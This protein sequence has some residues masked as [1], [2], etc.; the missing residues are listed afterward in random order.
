MFHQN[1]F[2]GSRI[3]SCGRRDFYSRHNRNHNYH[4]ACSLLHS[5][6][7]VL[8]T[9]RSHSPSTSC[10]LL[11]QKLSDCTACI[12][13]Y[14]CLHYNIYS[15]VSN[16]RVISLGWLS[17]C[18]ILMVLRRPFSVTTFLQAIISSL[19]TSRASR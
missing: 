3:V 18:T 5:S 17:L 1:P 6:L 8:K 4:D 19:H 16:F 9:V 10:S 11:C 13:C 14:C 7:A 12:E 2:S 15:K